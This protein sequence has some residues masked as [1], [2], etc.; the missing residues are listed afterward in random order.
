MMVTSPHPCVHGTVHAPSTV[1]EKPIQQKGLRPPSTRP[2]VPPKGGDRGRTLG[3]LEG[4]GAQRPSGRPR[5]VHGLGG[6]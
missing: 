1:W 5:G 3:R 2:R 6:L 4:A